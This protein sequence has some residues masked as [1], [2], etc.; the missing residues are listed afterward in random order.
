MKQNTLWSNDDKSVAK[1]QILF[2]EPLP[3]KQEACLRMLLTETVPDLKPKYQAIK[4]VLTAHRPIMQTS[5]GGEAS[6]PK[7]ILDAITKKGNITKDELVKFISFFLSDP[8]N[9]STYLNSLEVNVRKVWNLIIENYFAS[10]HLLKRETGEEWMVIGSTSYYYSLR[11]SISAKLPWFSI[12]KSNLSYGLPS[13]FYMFV[14][15]YYRP[16]LYPVFLTQKINSYI[17]FTDLPQEESL[18]IFSEEKQIFKLLPVMESLYKQDLLQIAKFR[19]TA[20]TLNKLIKLFNVSEFFPDD[21]DKTASQLRAS[22]LLSAYSTYRSSVKETNE[23]EIFIKKLVWTIIQYSGVLLAV[24]LPHVGGIKQKMLGDSYATLQASHILQL[25]TSDEADKWTD[26]EYIRLKLYGLE[27]GGGHNMLFSGNTLYKAEFVNTKQNKE[28]ILMDDMYR[29]MGVPFIKGFLF[30]LASLGVVEVAYGEHD[31]QS[32]SYCCSL[33]YVRLT[34]LGKYVLNLQQEYTPETSNECFFEINADD[35]IVRS[36]S[37]D[38]PYEALLTDIATPI[39]RHRYKVTSGSFLGNCT[40]QKD[41]E[42]KIS[43][44]RKHVCKQLPQNW[45]SFFNTLLQ[46]CNPLQ[47]VSNEKY[48]VYQLKA[49]DKELQRLVSTDPYLRQYTKRAEDYLLLIET[50]HLR[51]VT[52]RLRSFGYLL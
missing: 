12:L 17:S 41:I 21:E 42:D 35:M 5:K 24:T 46:Q 1:E 49:E 27:T 10:N 51:E 50:E 36:T 43:F 11:A 28:Y 19:I 6:L 31:S 18:Q 2:Y 16:Y 20:S 52:N 4:D 44:F 38:N 15:V 40:K 39:G 45:E 37:E 23:P 8:R 7:Y 9:F 22:M 14:S 33:R 29:E 48:R 47:K 34:P 3:K 25:L 30:L 13:D 26:I 32:A